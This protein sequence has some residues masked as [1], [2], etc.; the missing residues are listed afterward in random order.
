MPVFVELSEFV[1]V[2]RFFAAEF[3][4]PGHHFTVG[5]S[6]K[7]FPD[8]GPAVARVHHALLLGDAA[9]GFGG[10]GL[11]ERP[12]QNRHKPPHAPAAVVALTG[13]AGSDGGEARSSFI[14]HAFRLRR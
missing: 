6:V 5:G 10:I 13:S 12:D 4:S 9:V 14:A 3:H 11:G 2:E 8:T 7:D 1:Q